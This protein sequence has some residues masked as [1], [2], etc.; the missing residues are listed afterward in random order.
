MRV[1][2][3]QVHTVPRTA[4]GIQITDCAQPL[5]LVATPQLGVLGPCSLSFCH[6][7]WVFFAVAPTFWVY[8]V[9]GVYWVYYVCGVCW[10]YGM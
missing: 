9:H 5:T 10:V 4:K 6:S 8:G 1:Y 2:F 3:A 7:F